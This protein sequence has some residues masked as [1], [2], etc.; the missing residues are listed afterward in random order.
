MSQLT[1]ADLLGALQA[2]VSGLES[3][4]GADVVPAPELERAKLMLD[5]IRLSLWAHLQ[6]L[7]SD[8]VTTFEQ[9]FRVRRAVE[10]CSRLKTDLDAQLLDPVRPEFADLWIVTTELSRSIQTKR[11]RGQS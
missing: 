8:D 10:L 4:S 7:H 9:Q 2:S 11:E 1:I 3:R 5:D 6:R